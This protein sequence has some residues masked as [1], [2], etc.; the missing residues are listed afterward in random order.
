MQC[1][2]MVCDMLNQL[3]SHVKKNFDFGKSL[4][5]SQVKCLKIT[6]SR[7]NLWGFK[8]LIFSWSSL[9]SISLMFFL[10]SKHHSEQ[11]WSIIDTFTE[12]IQMMVSQMLSTNQSIWFGVVR[13]SKERGKSWTIKWIKRTIHR[14]ANELSL[15]LAPFKFQNNDN[16]DRYHRKPIE[17][18]N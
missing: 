1:F 5:M 11:K 2:V 7:S 8:P 12:Q 13:L 3:K 4:G 18:M 16:N 9:N 17:I 10:L 14:N 6:K 15:Y